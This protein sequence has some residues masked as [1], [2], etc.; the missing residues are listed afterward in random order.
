MKLICCH[1]KI[2]NKVMNVEVGAD[3]YLLSL[4]IP[5]HV[6]KDKDKARRDEVRRSELQVVKPPNK[7]PISIRR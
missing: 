5:Q 7:R 1:G 2:I 6:N 3:S 4:W